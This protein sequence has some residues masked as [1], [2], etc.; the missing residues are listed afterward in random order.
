MRNHNLD[1]SS[2]NVIFLVL[3]GAHIILVGQIV[4]KKLTISWEN[5]IL[6]SYCAL[7]ASKYVSVC[8]PR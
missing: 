6:P 4:G 1:K 7:K 3:G 2:T 8:W 5:S